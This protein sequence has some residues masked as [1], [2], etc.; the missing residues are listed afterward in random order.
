MKA[1]Y[2]SWSGRQF[3]EQWIRGYSIGSEEA[4]RSGYRELI[5]LPNM[6]IGLTPRGPKTENDPVSWYPI[7]PYRAVNR[8]P[9]E[10]DYAYVRAM[11]QTAATRP[12]AQQN[13]SSIGFHGAV[14]PE[15]IETDGDIVPVAAAHAETNWSLP[16]GPVGEPALLPDKRGW[17]LLSL[18]ELDQPRPTADQEAIRRLPTAGQWGTPP[19]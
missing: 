5:K 12:D 16:A 10:T 8:E 18:D 13:E 6:G 15:H 2:V 4:A 1:E 7:E 3:V 14:N 17:S 9:T 11:D 19:R